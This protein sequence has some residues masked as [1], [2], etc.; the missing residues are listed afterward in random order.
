MS[1]ILT[2]LL[3]VAPKRYSVRKWA[4]L[5]KSPIYNFRFNAV[6]NGVD[7]VYSAVHFVDIPYTFHNIEGTGFPGEHGPWL[8]PNPFDGKAKGYYDLARLV[9]RVWISFTSDL[10]PNLHGGKSHPSSVALMSIA[11]Y[12]ARTSTCVGTLHFRAAI[13]DGL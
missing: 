12:V 10:D 4:E 6:P 9:A 11:D 1:T 3:M 2:D 13:T 5:N 8:G 7:D